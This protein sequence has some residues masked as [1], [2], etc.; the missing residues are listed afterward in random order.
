M[1]KSMRW[2]TVLAV[3]G[4]AGLLT[5]VLPGRAEAWWRGGWWC[6]GVGVGVVLPPVVVA[7]PVYAP[8][9]VYYAPPPAA[10]YAP[11]R[12]MWVPPHWQGTVWV[13]GHWA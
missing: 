13:P 5:A 4:V 12:R 1:L 9:P 3:A 11:P 10:Y 6:C 7:P 2:G 8:P